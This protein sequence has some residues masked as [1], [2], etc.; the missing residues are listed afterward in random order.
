MNFI[1]FQLLNFIMHAA[2]RF[3]FFF[4]FYP[5]QHFKLQVQE[6]LLVGII[7]L[8]RDMNLY[9]DFHLV[10][11]ANYTLIFYLL[12]NLLNYSF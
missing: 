4:F 8:I 6:T 2:F 12:K 5:F 11:N 1:F 9:K 7:P 3:G 10:L